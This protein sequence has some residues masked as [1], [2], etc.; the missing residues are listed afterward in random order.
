MKKEY[1]TTVETLSI[2]GVSGP[3]RVYPFRTYGL[4]GPLNRLNSIL[5]LLHPLDRYRTPSAIGSAIGRP[6][7]LALSRIQTQVGVLNRLVLNRLGAQPCD[8][9]AIAS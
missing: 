1:T 4:S 9:G 2:S 8:G 6:P 5:S 3:Y 7:Y